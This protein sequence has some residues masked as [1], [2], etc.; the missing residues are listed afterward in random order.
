MQ[1]TNIPDKINKR[2]TVLG[3]L[4]H[5][6][7]KEQVG[8][9][10]KNCVQTNLKTDPTEERKESIQ[11]CHT[12]SCCG[13][14]GWRRRWWCWNARRIVSMSVSAI[15]S[16]VVTSRVFWITLVAFLIVYQSWPFSSLVTMVASPTKPVW[17]WNPLLY[18]GPTS[19]KQLVASVGQMFLI[20]FV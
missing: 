6:T 8:K 1:S 11:Y 20:R 17:C 3:F 4:P 14:N 2:V 15:T 13:C 18:P 9:G 16:W 19:S 7:D 10:N 5:M 12:W